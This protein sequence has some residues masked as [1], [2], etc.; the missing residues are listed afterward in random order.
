MN[1]AT[2]ANSAKSANS[3]RI[4]FCLSIRLPPLWFPTWYILSLALVLQFVKPHSSKFKK[5]SNFF[6]GVDGRGGLGYYLHSF[7]VFC[8]E[9]V[10]F[11]KRKNV[12][13]SH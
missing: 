4:F 8:A 1:P 7:R 9:N 12:N 6:L 2:V 5:K 10:L 3:C 13:L 11:R